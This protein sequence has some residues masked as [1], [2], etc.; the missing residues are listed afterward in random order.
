MLV[1]SH[2]LR[3]DS[4]CFKQSLQCFLIAALKNMTAGE[5]DKKVSPPFQQ[6]LRKSSPIDTLRPPQCIA[7]FAE[8]NGRRFRDVRDASGLPP[9]PERLRQRRDQSQTT[10]NTR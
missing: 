8:L 10:V 3:G 5:V 9:T 6:V 7:P 2:V 1:A 4:N